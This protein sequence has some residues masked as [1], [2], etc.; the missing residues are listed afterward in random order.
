M[1]RKVPVLRYAQ[2]RRIACDGCVANPGI[3]TNVGVQDLFLLDC[4]S[5]CYSISYCSSANFVM[6]LYALYNYAADKYQYIFTFL[7]IFTFTFT[8]TFNSGCDF[9]ERVQYDYYTF[10]INTY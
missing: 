3:N 7:F 10:E 6:P 1:L 4:P 8:F 9:T 2:T 5:Y